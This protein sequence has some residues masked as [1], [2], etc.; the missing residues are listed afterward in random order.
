[1]AYATV[2]NLTS[3]LQP[4]KLSCYSLTVTGQKR[5]IVTIDVSESDRQIGHSQGLKRQFWSYVFDQ[6]FDHPI[7]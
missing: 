7:G 5:F 4:A 2:R 3:L 1:M 6:G